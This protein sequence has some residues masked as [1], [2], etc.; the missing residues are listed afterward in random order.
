MTAA[1][2]LTIWC[3]AQL[4]TIAMDEL[5][6]GVARHRLILPAAR[7][8]NLAAGAPDPGLADADVAFGQP[9]PK[10]V[11]ELQRLKWVQLTSAGYTRYDNPAVRDALRARSAMLTNS[12]GVFAEPCAQHLLAM[13]LALSRRLPQ[14]LREQDGDRA[15]KYRELRQQSRLLVGESVLILGFGAIAKRI[16]ELLAP[17]RMKIVAI[18]RRPA[19]DELVPTYP[20]ADTERLLADADHVVNTLPGSAATE[21]FV[22]AD[23]LAKM[24]PGAVFYNIGRGTTVDQYALRVALETGRLSAAYLDVTTPEPLPPHDPLWTTPHCFI[25]PHTAGGHATEF[26]RVV[27]HFLDNLRR[28]EVGER[29]VDR[30]F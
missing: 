26:D 28:Y 16:V 2:P 19:G 8:D 11:I 23:R 10:Q 9:E 27:R 14:A 29:L 22:N 7:G 3:N 1:A 13:M 12:S 30:V 21:C 4:P 25:T 24:K 20:L 17:F 18:R 5:R 15:W 6:A